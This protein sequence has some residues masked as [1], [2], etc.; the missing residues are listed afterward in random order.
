MMKWVLS[1]KVI[2][3]EKLNCNATVRTVIYPN[4]KI[5][6][7]VQCEKDCKDCEYGRTNRSRIEEVLKELDGLELTDS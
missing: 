3:C 1:E 4:E 7:E 2:R 5:Y 6:R